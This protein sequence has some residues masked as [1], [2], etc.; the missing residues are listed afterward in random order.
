MPLAAAAPTDQ[1]FLKYDATLAQWVAAAIPATGGTVTSVGSGAGLT[2]GPITGSGTIS[3]APGGVTN[4]ML[5]NPS[6]TVA[7]GAGL[8][9]GGSVALGGSVTLSLGIVGIGN[10]GTGL[11]S[12]PSLQSQFL[13]GDATGTAWT[14]GAISR[15]RSCRA[16]PAT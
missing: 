12:G 14:A 3:I 6:L 5:V 7:A 9:G 1:Q 8:N 2:G 16:S 4:A 10:G 11:T 15:G 13:R